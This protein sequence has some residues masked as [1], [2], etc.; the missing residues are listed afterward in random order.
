MDRIPCAVNMPRG[1]SPHPFTLP[2]VINTNR[3]M[4]RVAL[5]TVRKLVARDLASEVD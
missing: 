4:P 2:R 3:V 1:P 5:V